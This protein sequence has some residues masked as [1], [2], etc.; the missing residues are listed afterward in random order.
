MVSKTKLFLNEAEELASTEQLPKAE[1]DKEES[2]PV[3]SHQSK[4]GGCKPLDSAL[5]REI[6]RHE[7]PDA[8]RVCVHDGHALLEI[9]AE[10]SEQ[11]QIIFEQVGVLQHHRIKHFCPCCGRSVQ[12][13]GKYQFGMP[14]YCTTALLRRSRGDIASNTLAAGVVHIGQP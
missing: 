4:K 8:E 10:I 11:L 5:H 3:A 2:N 13:T 12:V 1:T 7:L 9:G 6:V 14:L